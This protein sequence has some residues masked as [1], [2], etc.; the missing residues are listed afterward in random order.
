MT[1][2]GKDPRAG[3]F[4]V[5]NLGCAKNQ[6]DAEVMIASLKRAGWKYTPDH[7]EDADLI[8]VNTCGFI[9]SAQEEAVDTLL[10]IH[11]VL[12]P[13]QRRQLGEKLAKRLGAK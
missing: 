7:P 12:T 9:K 1:D 8:I 5:E 6:V 3:T 10:E 4:Y 11:A 13:A 2:S